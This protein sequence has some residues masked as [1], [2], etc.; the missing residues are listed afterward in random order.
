M[1]PAAIVGLAVYM[2]AVNLMTPPAY[3]GGVVVAA[4]G[5]L[6]AGAFTAVVLMNAAI[7]LSP[8]W[9]LLLV[10]VVAPNRM[11]ALLAAIQ[12]FIRRYGHTALVALLL[13]VGAWLILRGVWAL[14][15]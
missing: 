6:S 14:T 12:R 3:L 15:Q 13:S 9:G 10:S 7:V 5:S 4:Q 8:V 1:G 11:D 2:E